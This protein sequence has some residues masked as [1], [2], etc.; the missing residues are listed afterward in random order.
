MSNESFDKKIKSKFES[1]EPSY[2]E[3]DWKNFAPLLQPKKPFW[4]QALKPTAYGVAAS[5][6]L[7]L[8]YFNLKLS[9]ENRQLQN[10]VNQ[11][12]NT[13]THI[14]STSS[15]KANSPTSKT[16]RDTIYVVKERNT[17][18]IATQPTSE[19]LVHRNVKDNTPILERKTD[20]VFQQNYLTQTAEEA[21]QKNDLK[22]PNTLD[23]N[24]EKSNHKTQIQD[25]T[26]QNV[27]Q[28]TTKQSSES[29]LLEA[30]P[31]VNTNSVVSETP[32][33]NIAPAR[34]WQLPDVTH[35]TKPVKEK[36]SGLTVGVAANVQEYYKCAGLVLAYN[37]NRHWEINTGILF[38]AQTLGD[39]DDD[40]DFR[41]KHNED[42]PKK[43]PQPV[44]QNGKFRDI[45]AC[46]KE[47]YI[48]IQAYYKYP[49][50]RYLQ[51]VASV[52]SNI[53]LNATEYYKYKY[54][55]S[56]Q[57]IVDG[58]LPVKKKNDYFNSVV[59]SIGLQANWKKFSLRAEPYC[60]FELKSPNPKTDL[61][62]IIGFRTQ[63]LYNF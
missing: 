35:I 27:V 13:Q 59:G 41:R 20:K 56:G 3:K 18:Q 29:L 51:G 47:I 63:L 23:N 17:T 54:E 44:P 42:F 52:G 31:I 21:T 11:H 34:D 1:F 2:S 8:S 16:I 58:N 25:N 53:S 6:I 62:N 57:P 7:V 48:P 46:L 40:D 33:L 15:D 49:F 50:N 43:F 28:Q 45:H 4:A 61:D 39:F 30:L 10:T 24:V 22:A 19:V 9:D 55:E 36:S 5:A 32:K 60:N 38:G 37:I 26:I 14:T 12:N